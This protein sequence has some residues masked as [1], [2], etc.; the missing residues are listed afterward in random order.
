VPVSSSPA[1]LDARLLRI[2][3]TG[4]TPSSELAAQLVV[5]PA[6]IHDSIHGLQQAGFEISRHPTLGF[7]L[8]AAPDRLLADDL[9]SRMNGTWLGEIAVFEATASTNDLAMRRGLQ[10]ATGPLAIFAE[11]QTAGR[12]RFG[13]KW[14]SMPREG[15]WMS[16]LLRPEIPF[17]QWPRLT[18]A[19]ALATALAIE[20]VTSLRPAIK[21]PNDVLVRG[22]KVSGLLVETGQHSVSGPFAV[23]GIGLNANQTDFPPDILDRATSLRLATGQSIDRTALAASLLENLGRLLPEL[24]YGFGKILSRITERSALLGQMLRVHTGHG[25]VEGIAEALDDE[26]LLLLRLAD[27]SLQRFSAGEVTLSPPAAG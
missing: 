10:G 27:G 5:A 6:Q 25:H 22:K 26:G 12:G 9:F 3:R 16:V 24:G 13:R 20:E 8:H 7:Q 15:V 4:P 2:L 21:W 11:S 18:S 1:S 19:A 23:L 14:H 17:F